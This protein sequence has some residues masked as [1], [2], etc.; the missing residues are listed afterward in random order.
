MRSAPQDLQGVLFARV[1]DLT[2][3]QNGITYRHQVAYEAAIAARSLV[4]S[5]NAMGSR[6]SDD[7]EPHV[8][9]FSAALGVPVYLVSNFRGAG[10]A[11]VKQAIQKA[12]QG[13]LSWL[14]KPRALITGTARQTRGGA[15]R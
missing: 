8:P 4:V 13:V 12:R 7:P 9:G 3:S 2:G 5:L 1:L 6:E 15:A 14:S 10:T 11:Q